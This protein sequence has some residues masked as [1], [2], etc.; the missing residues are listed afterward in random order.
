MSLIG[1]LSEIKLADVLRLFASG[2][3]T[4]VLTASAPGQEA[5]LR[6]Q[7]GAIV[8]ATSARLQ[9]DEAVLDLF[10]WTEGQLTFL[11]EEKAVTPNVTHGI[12]VLILE[13][14]RLGPAFHRMNAFIPSD[15]VVFQMASP[16][17]GTRYTLGPDEWNVVRHVDS[18]R[19]VK[20]IVE[21]TGLSRGQVAGALFEL[22]EAGF[23]EK[24]ELQKRLRAQGPR[25]FSSFS[26][27]GPDGR[28]PEAVELEEKLQEEWR[29]CAA[30][31]PGGAAGRA[32]Y[33]GLQEIDDH[34]RGVPLR[35]G[36]GR[37]PAAALA[38]GAGRARGRRPARAARR[39]TGRTPGSASAG[40]A[41]AGLLLLLDP[42]MAAAARRRRPP[43]SRGSGSCARPSSPRNRGQGGGRRLPRRIQRPLRAGPGP[44]R[45][46]LHS[47]L[48][49]RSS[50]LWP[51][52]RRPSIPLARLLDRARLRG[53]EVHAWVN[54]LL[55]AHFGLALPPGHV[56]RMHPE[57][58]MV[59]KAVATAALAARP[60]DLA[61]LVGQAAAP[62]ATWRAT[63]SRPPRRRGGRS[64][65]RGGPRAGASAT[66]STACT[67]T[68]SAIPAP[69][70]TTPGLP[71]KASARR[72]AA[73]GTCFG[74]PRASPQAWDAYRRACLTSLVTRLGAAIR[75]ANPRL[76]ISAAVV[77]DEAQAVSQ[78]L[79]GLAEVARRGPPRR[80]LS[81]GLHPG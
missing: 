44:R 41:L 12:E 1:T 29:K 5:I 53:L 3:K 8:H 77:P 59:P 23:L 74:R 64:P 76:R 38:P 55:T 80:A 42:T 6:I 65:R 17:D 47:R 2:K 7:K 48:V 37:A 57:W 61:R 45:R 51:S 28:T 39:V 19:D 78:K 13:G 60:A 66:R 63:T 35:P 10:G 4:G 81:D 21:A 73:R 25:A 31:Q 11:P 16:R 68:S 36:A 32:A 69:T 9:G 18:V 79:P 40:V 46:L 43:S 34:G 30:F 24:I 27:L 62:A 52:A 54:V 49:A 22:G 67:S 20:E 50:L 58:M 72:T 33:P 26:L 56:L 70:T 71:S 15:S 14:E 75:A